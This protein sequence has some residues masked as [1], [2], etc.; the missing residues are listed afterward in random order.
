MSNTK[1]SKDYLTNNQI[2]F[3]SVQL[4]DAAGERKGVMTIA[5]ALR[6]AEEAELDLIA[7]DERQNPPVCRI[8]DLGK[9]KYE[10]DKRDHHVKQK[11]VEIKEIQLT[12][13]IGE[14]DLEIKIRKINEFL[15]EGNRVK[16]SMRLKGREGS[17]PE[18][19]QAIWEKI[20]TTITG[21]F[22]EMPKNE[23]KYMT[24]QVAPGKPQPKK[25]A[26]PKP[27]NNSPVSSVK[28]LEVAPEPI[29]ARVTAKPGM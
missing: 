22:T 7:I 5:A 9:Y 10:R 2:T 29:V 23:F 12:P 26:Q 25:Q 1:D 19:T 27:A 4:L 20:D 15:A 28:P 6:L 16:I 17:H 21:H 8:M 11:T 13:R 14:H 18:V 3:P 24:A